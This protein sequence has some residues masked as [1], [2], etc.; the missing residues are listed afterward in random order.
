MNSFQKPLLF[1][2]VAAIAVTMATSTQL[3]VFASPKIETVGSN[4]EIQ[5]MQRDS[6]CNYL[7]K[8]DR[9]NCAS[10]IDGWDECGSISGGV[11]YWK[12]YISGCME[13][14]NTKEACT[15]MVHRQVTREHAN[16][17]S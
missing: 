15:D 6:A 17:N 2:V 7:G 10:F 9:M 16:G 14:G 12:G 5:Q 13:V 3:P 8:H 4:S 1:A 11:P